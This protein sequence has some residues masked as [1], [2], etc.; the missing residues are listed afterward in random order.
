MLEQGEVEIALT[1]PRVDGSWTGPPG[2]RAWGRLED[3]RGRGRSEPLPA[4]QS[5]EDLAY[6]IFTSG[7]TGRPK[8]V[9]IDH[10][11]ALN[12][13][14]GRQPALRGRV[15]GDRVLA[16]S[17]LIFDLSVWDLFGVLAAGGT[18]VLPEPWASRDPGRWLELDGARAGDGVEHRAG[19]DGDAGRARAGPGWSSERCGW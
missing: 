1:Q 14:D 11:G 5:P 19:A 7:S 12:T 10:R 3:A 6:V 18:V 4:V 17:S 2:W 13:V 15:P 16:L 9:M 8:G